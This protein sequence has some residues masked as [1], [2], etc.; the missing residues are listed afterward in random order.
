M[1]VYALQHIYRKNWYDFPEFK[2]YSVKETTSAIDQPQV[3][4]Q[5]ILSNEKSRKLLI[6]LWI[7]EHSKN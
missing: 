7:N 1:A 5:K 3:W 2:K 6:Q 4:L